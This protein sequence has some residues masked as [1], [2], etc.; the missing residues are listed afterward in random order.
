[1]KFRVGDRVVYRAVDSGN[2][3]LDGWAGTVIYVDGTQAPYTVR[4][5]EY[6]HGGI[7]DE[8]CPPRGGVRR[9][10]AGG[11]DWFCREEN[12]SPLGVRRKVRRGGGRPK[13][14]AARERSEGEDAEGEEAE[15]CADVEGHTKKQEEKDMARGIERHKWTAEEDAVI[16]EMLEGGSSVVD[17]CDRLGVDMVTMKNRLYALRKADPTFPRCMKRQGRSDVAAEGGSDVAACGNGDVAACGSGDV[18]TG[19]L[20]ELEQAL[21]DTLADVTRERDEALAELDSAKK[22]LLDA[23]EDQDELRRE[24]VFESVG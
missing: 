2:T 24:L 23:E 9:A 14:T 6:Y 8:R 11:D 5:D 3:D 1:M 21:A 7:T 17:I 20:G 22:K 15:G 16:R 12:L 13:G 18:P 19:T 10:A 4:F